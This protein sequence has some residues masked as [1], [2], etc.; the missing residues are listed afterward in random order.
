MN[1]LHKNRKVIFTII[2]VL[3]IVTVYLIYNIGTEKINISSS[4]LEKLN[5][6]DNLLQV[7]ITVPL[8]GMTI[9][10]ATF[11]GRKII[12]A[13]DIQKHLISAKRDFINAF[14]ILIVCTIMIFFFDF[15]ETFL[16]EAAL[17]LISDIVVTFGTFIFGLI[18]LVRGVSAL[19]STSDLGA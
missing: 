16:S 12:D 4:L 15:I 7:N 6:A 8:A 3:I 11:L 14:Y 17:V 13:P 10:A 19:K 9:A 18:F 1:M 2:A 5:K